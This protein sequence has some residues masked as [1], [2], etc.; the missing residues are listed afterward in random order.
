[1]HITFVLVLRESFNGSEMLSWVADQ[2]EGSKHLSVWTCKETASF[3]IV[4]TDEMLDSI[5]KNMA[6]LSK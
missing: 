6:Y 3:E 2:R 5:R 1:V 4:T